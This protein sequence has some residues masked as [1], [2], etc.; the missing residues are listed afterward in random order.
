MSRT[1]SPQC[2]NRPMHMLDWKS[3]IRWHTEPLLAS[4]GHA[5]QAARI[6]TVPTTPSLR[7]NRAPVCRS[8][9][10]RPVTVTIWRLKSLGLS[11]PQCVGLWYRECRS[12]LSTP[13]CGKALQPIPGGNGVVVPYALLPPE[14]PRLRGGPARRKMRAERR[15]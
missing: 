1:D 3:A 9:H 12:S 11:A 8:V 15:R 6:G 4:A 2:N 7:I 10:F 5:F 13:L 14:V